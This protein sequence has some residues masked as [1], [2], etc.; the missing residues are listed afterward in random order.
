[1]REV[2]GGLAFPEGPIA[3]GDGSVLLVEIRRGTLTRV[4]PS[5][6]VEVVAEL[7]SGPNGAAIGPDGAVYVCNNGGFEW[8]DVG[9]IATPGN[10]S[11]DYRGGSIQ[12]VVLD[13]PDAGTFTE[14]YT[15][16]DGRGLRGPNDI[17]FDAEGGFWF[18][19]L[20]KRRPRD[21]DTGAVYY[22]TPDGSSIT[23]VLHPMVQPNGIG[24]SPDGSRLYVAET[25]P[26]R[27][28]YWDVAGPGQL[29]PAD[30]PVGPHG[31]SLLHGFAGFQ[32]LDSLAVD[33]VGNVC[34]ATLRTG[35]VS[36]LNPDGTLER[37]VGVPEPDP[38]VTNICFA[39]AGSNTA[40]V[41]SSGLGRLYVTEWPYPG[42]DLAFGA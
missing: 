39:G 37:Q 14:L 13:G 12:R 20:G 21:Y 24:L 41:T 32:L 6:R 35:A 2:A 4:W 42:L 5:G 26:G 29:R 23:E 25:G 36:I 27:V 31:G 15:E 18:T 33:G 10:Q 1:M 7:G 9:G 3:L 19:D 28:W 38:Y 16:V 11:A 40:W 30:R 17:V 34:V 22:A 8:D